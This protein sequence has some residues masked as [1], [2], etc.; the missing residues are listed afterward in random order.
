MDYEQRMFVYAAAAQ[1][2]TS[3]NE[4]AMFHPDFSFQKR[5]SQ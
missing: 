3:R 2:E 1:L 4:A 5:F